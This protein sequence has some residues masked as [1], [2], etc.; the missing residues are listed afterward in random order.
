MICLNTCGKCV[1]FKNFFH[2]FGLCF[3]GEKYNGTMEQKG[4]APVRFTGC[5]GCKDFESTA[6]HNAWSRGYLYGYSECQRRE[7]D[8]LNQELFRSQVCQGCQKEGCGNV[9]HA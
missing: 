7:R 1:G 9:D 3:K 4:R 2:G 8:K 6:E 5:R